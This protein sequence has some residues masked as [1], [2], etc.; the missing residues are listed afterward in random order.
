MFRWVRRALLVVALGVLVG[1]GL[2][3]LTARPDL[4][5]GRSDVEDRWRTLRTALDT[6]YELLAAANAATQAQG[7]PEREIVTQVNTALS[8]WR[9]DARAPVT[10]QIED[11]NTLEALGRRLTTTVTASAR[12]KSLTTVT[13]PTNRFRDAAFPVSATGFNR[14]VRDYEDARGGSLRRPIAGLLG[15]DSIAGLDVPGAV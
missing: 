10:R 2:L 5:R 14:A 15:Y 7:G 6:R 12:L 8:R 3:A 9:G 4:Q 13:T 1:G 11:A